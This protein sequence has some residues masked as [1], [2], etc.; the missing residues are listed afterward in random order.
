MELGKKQK[1]KVAYKKDFGVYLTDLDVELTDDV[2]G[3]LLP[4]RQVPEDTQV[5]DVIEVFLYKDSEGRKIATTKTPMM[6]IGELAYLEIAEITKIG[7]FLKW[8]LERD[9]FLP[10]KEQTTEIK[11]H[12]KYLVA[13]YLDKSERLCATMRIYNYLRDDSEYVK[14]DMVKGTIY[15]IQQEKGVFIAVDN[16]YYGMLP[17]QELLPNMKIGQSIEARVFRVREDGKLDL[18][19]NRPIKEQIEIDAEKVFKII[20]EFGGELPFGEKVSAEIILREFGMSK[21]S[22]KRALGHLLKNQKITIGEN[23]IAIKS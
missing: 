9:L 18:V 21:A 14:N 22:F 16:K 23:A 8:G 4:N 5:G 2:R 12:E 6:E 10:F 17:K 3:V 20:G 15:Q 1:L 19:S 11:V 7:A 13:M